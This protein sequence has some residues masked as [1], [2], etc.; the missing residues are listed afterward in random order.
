MDHITNNK[1]NLLTK[2][3]KSPD[4]NCTA[5]VGD[6]STDCFGLMMET[7]KFHINSIKN[8]NYRIRQEKGAEGNGD[9][10]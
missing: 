7:K 9:D 2:Q 6:G 1:L 8:K 4:C 5:S 10:F 3:E